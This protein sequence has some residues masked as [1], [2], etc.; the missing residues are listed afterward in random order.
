MTRPAILLLA[1]CRRAAVAAGLAS[2]FLAAHTTHAAGPLRVDLGQDTGRSDTDTPGWTE[3]QVKNGAEATRDFDGV[4]VTLRAAGEGQLNGVFAKG[5]LMTTTL[6]A[7][8]VAVDR[9]GLEM[10]IEGLT[11]GKH[12][13]ATYHNIVSGPRGDQLRVSV[14]PTNAQAGDGEA[15][16]DNATSSRLVAPSR[17]VQSNDDIASGYVEFT[18]AADQPVL[19]RVASDAN[20][21]VILNG[22]EIDGSDPTK[23]NKTPIP[24]DLDWHY[25]A[26]GRTVEFS[27][28]PAASAVTH[29][30]YLASD[31]DPAKAKAA[32]ESATLESPAHVGETWNPE[33][34]EGRRP[35]NAPVKRM[36]FSVSVAE[37]D[38]L[39][40]FFW[41]VD[42]IHADGKITKGDVWAFRPRH[43]AFPGAEGYG[44]FAIGGRGGKVVKVTNLNDSGPGSLRAAVELNEPRT[45]M[46]DVSGKIVLKS[47]LGLRNPYLTIA[48]Q[49][50]PGKGICIANYNMG[51]MGSHDLIVR[52]MRVRPGNTS[53][54][55][56]DGM[57]MASSTDCI[58]DHCSISWTHDE[59]FS[60][61]G[62]GN[63][64]LQRTL[65]SEALN[66]AGHRNYEPGKQHGYAA[67]IGGDIG[68]FHHNLLAHCSGRN[69]SLAGG[70][71]K[72]TRH[73]GRLDIRNN[74]VY[75]WGHRTTDGGAK[76]VVFVNNYYKPG[77]AS[78]VFHVLMAER[79]AVGAFGPQMYFVEGNVMEGRFGADERYAGVF[80]RRREPIEA[81]TVDKPFYESFVTTQTAEEAYQ[82]VL[83]DVGCNFPALD[84]HDER[85]IRETRDGTTTYKGSVSGLP[86]LPDTQDDV[87]GWDEYPEV[88][89]PADWDPDNDGM[90]SAWET[91]QGFNPADPADANG[92]KNGDGYTNLEEY[93][94]GLVAK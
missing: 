52:Y 75:N 27:W 74:V 49:T 37:A 87:G 72:A 39:K 56:L 20:A 44:R 11:P 4:K 50:A 78:D 22:F 32:V 21:N 51:A 5:L 2:V 64:T 13:V 59:A 91:E 7:D 18:A 45:V 23:K 63:I 3:W 19:V 38:N 31:L 36:T 66:V 73:A 58:Y 1:A 53:G 77:P 9:G 30:F 81:W 65:I 85:V 54:E 92:D 61:R 90:P 12:T 93:L 8:G 24:A 67:S 17:D 71:D 89:R 47:T 40:H 41:R 34:R 76:E 33:V 69:W 25:N 68:S 29:E 79:E 48:G 84:E 35:A 14:V 10:I 26:R 83:A 55:T 6:G 60:S 62:A 28:M 15:V 94:N 43:L 82:N 80:E 86:G 42:S 16:A 46:F 88:H 57:G 70:L